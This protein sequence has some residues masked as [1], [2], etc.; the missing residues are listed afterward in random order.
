MPSG[1]TGLPWQ[2]VHHDRGSPEGHHRIAN[3]GAGSHPHHSRHHRRQAT[4]AAALVPAAAPL[5]MVPKPTRVHPLCLPNSG[6]L[7]RNLARPSSVMPVMR[8]WP[9]EGPR[10]ASRRYIE[11][12]A[13]S[14]AWSNWQV[15]RTSLSGLEL[16]SS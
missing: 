4:E 11:E 7:S 6:V 3:K 10:Y 14:N 9:S 2:Q 15:Y 13:W 8:G 1:P 5:L 12:G 16:P